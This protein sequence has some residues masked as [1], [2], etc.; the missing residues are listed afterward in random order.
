MRK[1]ENVEIT[2]NKQIVVDSYCNWCRR[3]LGVAYGNRDYAV[4]EFRL[5]FS[6]GNSFPES[7]QQVGWEVSDLCDDCLA[8]LKQWLSDQGVEIEPTEVDW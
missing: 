3:S 2:Y 7:G 4:R 8:K 6:E 1:Y 5:S